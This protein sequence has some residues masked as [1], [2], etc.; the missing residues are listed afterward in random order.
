MAVGTLE[1]QLGR[2]PDE[3]DISEELHW[4]H[5]RAALIALGQETQAVGLVRIFY[6]EDNGSRRY[7]AASQ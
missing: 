2:L 1:R 3:R 6:E 5:S 7:M 4:T